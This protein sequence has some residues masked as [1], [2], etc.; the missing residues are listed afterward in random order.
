[1][2]NRKTDSSSKEVFGACLYV[3]WIASIMY[4][5]AMVCFFFVKSKIN[6]DH[7]KLEKE[8]QAIVYQ[9]GNTTQDYGYSKQPV[10]YI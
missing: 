2:K 8:N 9:Q 6:K 7:R 5:A 3:G 4:F 10:E 1:M